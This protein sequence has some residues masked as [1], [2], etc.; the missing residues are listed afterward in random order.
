[1]NKSVIIG[2]GLITIL[3]IVSLGTLFTVHQR[4]QALILQF[5]NPVRVIANPGLQIKIPFIQNVEYYDRRILDLDPPVQ[6][7][8]LSDQKRVNVDAFARYKIV[9]P[10]EFRKKA[11]TDANFRQV[12]GNRLNSAV[13]EEIGK[14]LLGDMLT[15]KRAQVMSLITQ[16]MKAQASEFG[17]EVVDVRIGRTDLPDTTAQAV[18]NRMQSDRVADAA[19]L[20]ANGEKEKLNIQAKANKTRTIIISEATKTSEILRGEGD[21]RR[22]KILNDAYGQDRS[23]FDFY[24]SMDALGNSVTE[25]TTMVLSPDSELFRF[26]NDIPKPAKPN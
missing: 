2:I 23:F 19:E 7:I 21:G 22:T 20:R 1:M 6:E 26:F 16:Q 11:L 10:L 25:G 9:D 8:I 17:T 4:E 3:A 24:R 14:I 13:R 18:Y 5:G 15:E 12:F